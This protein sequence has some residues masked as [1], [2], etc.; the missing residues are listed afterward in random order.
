MSVVW[1]AARGKFWS[2]IGL[3]VSC[4]ACNAAPG[5]ECINCPES[6]HHR[7]RDDLA[8]ALGF[9]MLVTAPLLEPDK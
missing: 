8:D 2:Y 9:R 7:V 1:P 3:A 6:Q 4:P 5:A